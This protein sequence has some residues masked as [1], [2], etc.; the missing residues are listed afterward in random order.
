MRLSKVEI[1]G[2]KSVRD[3]LV[4]HVDSHVTVLLGANDHGKTNVLTALEHLNPDSPFVADTDPCYDTADKAHL[5]SLRCDFQLEEQERATLL[6]A[7][8]KHRAAHPPSAAEGA[9][10]PSEAVTGTLATGFAHAD[11][12]LNAV[13]KLLVLT[14][15]GVGNKLIPS[16]DGISEEVVSQFIK[17]HLPR[18]ELIRPLDRAPDSVTHKDLADEKGDFMRGIFYHAGLDPE[19]AEQW[20]KQDDVTMKRLEQASIE[21]TNSLKASWSQGANLSFRL[22]HNSKD[23]SIELRI[24]DP[25]VRIQ[26]VRA[27]RRS[28]GFTH[29]FTL[30]TILYGRER[31]NPASSYIYL[32]DEPGVYLHPDGQRDLLKALDAIGTTNQ[33]IYTT[34]SIFMVNKSYPSRHRLIVKDKNGTRIDSKP[35]QGRWGPAID[36]LGWAYSGTILFAN[37]VLLTE[38]DSDP[39]YLQALF[40]KLISQE[41]SSVDLNSFTAIP[42]GNARD[43]IALI[44]MLRESNA[45]PDMAVLVDGDPAGVK[46]I[47]ILQPILGYY[48]LKAKAFSLDEG[49][50][51]EDYLPLQKDGYLIALARYATKIATTGSRE[52]SRVKEVHGKLLEQF[53]TKY[54]SGTTVKGLASWAEEVVAGIVGLT[55]S[56]SKSGVAREYVNLLHEMGKI[57]DSE[58]IR[59]TPLCA[60]IEKVL[61]IPRMEAPSTEVI[62]P[63]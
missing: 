13:P 39:I 62:N 7:E 21:L 20:F 25:A 37:Y 6:D 17:D 57:D 51:I 58:L 34:H 1:E 22:M 56:P 4:L 18:V 31:D 26:Y 59:I 53:G 12:S 11:L 44:K 43:G 49:C 14:R 40:Q 54:P 32:F 27:S 42:M 28:S 19:T 61:G 38:G 33:V 3:K 60:R 50:E 29:F 10:M 63:G 24:S 9:S 46:I 35:Y 8:K 36:A 52:E 15:S 48:D 30:K 16:L 47:E 23:S 45:A 55:E 2:Y 41:K 5:P